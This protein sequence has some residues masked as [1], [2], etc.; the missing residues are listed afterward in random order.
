MHS[1]AYQISLIR[2]TPPAGNFRQLSHCL[3]RPLNILDPSLIGSV[4]TICRPLAP[5]WSPAPPFLRKELYHFCPLQLQRLA[6][7]AESTER[8]S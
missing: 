4:P 1:F 6:T 5:L 7:Q 3:D 8:R 2:V